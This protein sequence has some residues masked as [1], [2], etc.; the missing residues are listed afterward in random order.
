MAGP[1]SIGL[2]QMTKSML[3][4]VLLVAMLIVLSFIPQLLVVSV[5]GDINFALLAA[6]WL[7]LFACFFRAGQS[8]ITLAIWTGAAAMAIPPVPNYVAIS[9]SDGPHLMWVG[10]SNLMTASGM[11]GVAFFLFFYGVIFWGASKLVQKHL[12]A[13]R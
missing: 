2:G 11:Y 12:P 5:L 13:A 8:L 6:I 4:R 1:A 10:W 3:L 9:Q 7:A